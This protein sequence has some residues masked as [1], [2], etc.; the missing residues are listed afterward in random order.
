MN[1]NL[2][3]LALA[4][5]VA[6]LSVG[7]Y[8]AARKKQGA[9]PPLTPI[10]ADAVTSASIAWPGSPEIKLLRAG[11]NWVLAAPVVASAD[12][13]EVLAI[14]N[15][16]TAEVQ[17]TLTPEGL[18]LKDIGLAPPDHRIT[19]NQ[20]A[21]DF[22]S[23]DPLKFTR[24]VKIGDRVM[25]IDDPAS[26]ALDKDYHDLVSK[27]LFAANEELV[28]IE[29]PTLSLSKNADG[30]WIAQPESALA[31]P[32]ALAKIADGWKQARAMWNEAGGTPPTGPT[33]KFTF[34]DGSTRELVVAG[35]EPQFALYSPATKVRYELSKALADELLKL[36][37]AKPA[38]APTPTRP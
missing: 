19:L 22:G 26:A 6:G 4:I 14:T 17:E 35:T 18:N 28:K 12:R 31:T 36:P 24:Y 38:A 29:L 16:A 11:K 34:K 21:I 15:L 33:L 5:L 3:N 27:E 7:A 23:T 10:A 9:H 30:K 32:V 37:E 8:F 25:L 13:F 20:V 1:R 2:L